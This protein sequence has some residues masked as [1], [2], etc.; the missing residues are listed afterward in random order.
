[1]SKSVYWLDGTRQ[2]DARL[3]TDPP[4]AYRWALPV[5]SEDGEL[6]RL[7]LKPADAPLELAYVY[8]DARKG[9]DERAEVEMKSVVRG[10]TAIGMRAALSVMPN[11]DAERALKAYWQQQNSWFQ[12]AVVSWNY[13]DDRGTMLLTAKGIGKLDWEGSA[14]DGRSLDI[15]GA[16]FYKPAELHRPPD[17]EQQAPWK[18]AFPKFKCWAT[19]ILLPPNDKKWKWDYSSDAI[20]EYLGGVHYWRRA[21]LRD[22]T[23]QTMMASNTEL[24]E[25][26]AE[27]AA[28]FNK[29]IAYFDNNMSRVYQI[30][31]KGASDDAFSAK[32]PLFPLDM[33]WTRPDVPCG[34]PDP[35]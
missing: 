23:M 18:L 20:D 21:D 13:D 30:N 22:G 15:F 2:G 31:A 27:Q 4:G 10:D 32:K 35:N 14:H 11:E 28:Q 12:P 3:K 19:V 1:V 5:R 9:F 16:G 6:E 25:L 7:P 26:T 24:P 33:D 34:V 8:A 29:G 17:Q